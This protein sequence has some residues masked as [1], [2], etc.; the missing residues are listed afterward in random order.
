MDAPGVTVLLEENKYAQR[1][2]LRLLQINTHRESAELS[3]FDEPESSQ[4]ALVHLQ[5]VP[6]K[7][8][9][10]LVAADGDA[11]QLASWDTAAVSPGSRPI[12]QVAER[13]SVFALLVLAS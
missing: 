2:R 9:A 5:T 10:R 7:G 11:V 8:V 13:S 4:E 1:L 3:I 6:A 12:L